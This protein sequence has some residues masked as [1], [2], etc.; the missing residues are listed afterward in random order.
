MRLAC[1][2][3]A[4][5]AYLATTMAE[6]ALADATTQSAN[7]LKEAQQALTASD[8]DEVNMHLRHAVN[9]LAGRD[10]GYYYAPDGDA[11]PCT[12]RASAASQATDYLPKKWLEEAQI[13]LSAAQ[14]KSDIQ[15]SHD[16]AEDA[17][18]LIQ[19][20]Q[21]ALGGG[22]VAAGETAAQAKPPG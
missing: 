22:V 6:P 8:H 3:C 12:D 19:K 20:S 18:K 21:A 5:A 4:V 1:R 11:G 14:A 2:L 16:L 13:W 7:A 9:C 10:S 17:I 15:S